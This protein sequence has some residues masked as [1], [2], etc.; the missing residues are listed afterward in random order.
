MA[1]A[2]AGLFLSLFSASAL[3]QNYDNPGLG[4]KPV[5]RHPQDFKPLGIRAGG[6]ML[7]PGVQLAAQW[8][9]NVFY[10]ELDKR[11]DLIWH[12]RP[13]ITAQSNWSRHAFNVRLAA[14]VARYNEYDFRDYED[15]FLLING[16]ID[17]R[18]RSYLS[19]N[20][21]FMRLHEDLN[22]RDAE[23]G[24][25]PTTYD[26]Y[27][28]TLRYDH[29]FNRLSIGVGYTLNKLD[30][31]NAYSLQDGIIDN[32]DRDRTTGTGEIR[33]GYQFQTD[34]QAFVS[35]QSNDVEYDLP[36][37]RNG[38]HRDNSGWTGNAGMSFTITNTMNGDLYVS[39]L[40]REY[41]DPRLSDISGWALGASLQ[42]APSRLT[43]VGFNVSSGIEETTSA[44]ASG[45]FMTLYSL[46]I[47]HELMRN[48]QLSG[49]VSYRNNDYELLPNAPEFARDEDDVWQAGLGV[50]YFV[51]RHV[52][53]N[54][55]WTY[56][57]LDSNVPLDDYDRN[58]IWLTLSLER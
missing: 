55:A 21:D 35:L 9:D 11:D 58:N 57:T 37:D 1:A 10:T 44:Y 28:G 14:D 40:E 43:S 5:S 48:V 46:R 52:F 16:R 30:F 4:E 22:N 17:V 39:Y 34:K 18:N 47:D 23:Q 27:G 25:E 42:W 26:M 29:T 50:N 32:Q 54:L 56:E 6:F 19:Y 38:F 49:F 20:L 8:T 7:H 15:Y 33:L 12:I 3:A 53:F 45:Y 2:V 31:D 24:F 51:N 36:V 41:D 13:Y